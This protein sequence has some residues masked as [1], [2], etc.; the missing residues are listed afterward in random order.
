LLAAISRKSFLG[1]IVNQPAEKRL[2]ATLGVTSWLIFQ[3]ASMIR[4]HDI[5]ETKDVITVCSKMLHNNQ[6]KNI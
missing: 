5:A 2:P 3:G 1:E 4:A 6:N